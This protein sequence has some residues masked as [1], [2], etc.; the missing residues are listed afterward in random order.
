MNG[1]EKVHVGYDRTQ[2]HVGPTQLHVGR[3]TEDPRYHDSTVRMKSCTL[4][5]EKS[6]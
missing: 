3:S 6:K 2:M 1:S 5:M 4:L